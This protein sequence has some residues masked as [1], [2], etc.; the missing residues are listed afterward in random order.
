MPFVDSGTSKK[1]DLENKPDGSFG[2]C[3]WNYISKFD[4]KPEDRTPVMFIEDPN[5]AY[6]ALRYRQ[7]HDY[8]HTLFQLPPSIVG[9]LSLKMIEFSQFKI[10][11]CL[12]SSTVGVPIIEMTYGYK[13]YL[14]FFS[15]EF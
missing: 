12:L 5:V 9:E 7:I 11:P 10:L 1:Y 15:F 13:K 2:K 14:I 4:F 3:Y 8:L 6:V